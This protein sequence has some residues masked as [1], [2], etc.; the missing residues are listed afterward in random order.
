MEMTGN[1]LLICTL[2]ST[3][4]SGQQSPS[5]GKTYSSACAARTARRTQCPGFAQRGRR[6]RLISCANRTHARERAADAVIAD[7]AVDH[8]SAVVEGRETASQAEYA[9][10]I[11]VIGSTKILFSAISLEPTPSKSQS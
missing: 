3:S 10:S 7:P 6:S 4:D 8:P 11:P 2:P 5:G 1:W 9:G